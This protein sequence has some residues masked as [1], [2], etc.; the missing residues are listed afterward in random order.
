[1]YTRGPTAGTSAACGGL[2]LA[3][4]V[5]LRAALLG[6]FG[7][8]TCGKLLFA[9]GENNILGAIPR[10]WGKTVVRAP[11]LGAFCAVTHNSTCRS[12]N[13]IYDVRWEEPVGTMG[14]SHACLR[15]VWTCC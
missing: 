12:V 4:Y 1:M 3:G 8:V 13:G 5:W 11:L 7:A 6:L 10:G 2:S 9:T 15:R 14:K